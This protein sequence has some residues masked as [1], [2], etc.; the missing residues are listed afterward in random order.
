MEELRRQEETRQ[1]KLVK[2]RE[3]VAI[4]ELELE[5]LPLY[6][7][8]KDELVSI[9]MSLIISFT[10]IHYHYKYYAK[11]GKGFLLLRVFRHEGHSG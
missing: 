3:E 7:P 10:F 6:V 11:V 1:Q 2:A 9:L 8:P 5:N 4:A